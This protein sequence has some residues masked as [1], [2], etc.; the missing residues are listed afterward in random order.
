MYRLYVEC[1]EYMMAYTNVVIPSLLWHR[2]EAEPPVGCG[3][4]VSIILHV[5]TAPI[6]NLGI[7]LV[8]VTLYR[9]G[10]CKRERR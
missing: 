10:G 6:L 3:C 2:E 4:T 8:S 7:G 5:S 9:F 1:V